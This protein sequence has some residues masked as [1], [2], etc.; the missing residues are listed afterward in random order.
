MLACSLDSEMMT[1]KRYSTKHVQ[2]FTSSRMKSIK[3]NQNKSTQKIQEQTT[4]QEQTQEHI[5][6]RTH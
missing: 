5:D 6:T 4:I 2:M 3:T 1:A